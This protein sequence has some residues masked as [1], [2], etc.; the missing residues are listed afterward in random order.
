MDS[1]DDNYSMCAT[2][3]SCNIDDAA[4]MACGQADTYTQKYLNIDA[5]IGGTPTVYVD[6][7]SVRTSYSAISRAICKSDPTLAGCNAA[8]P[9][10]AEKEIPMELV[11]SHD[12][13][14]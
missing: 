6:G 9:Y 10:G 1:N 3:G 12:V 2:A 13:L 5:P 11:P 14:A 7:S 4:T 8:M